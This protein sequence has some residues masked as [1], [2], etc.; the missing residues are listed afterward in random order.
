MST[1]LETTTAAAQDPSYIPRGPVTAELSF[2]DGTTDGATPYA[3]P[4]EPPAGLPQTNC[5]TKPYAVTI[6]DIRGEESKYTLDHD[7][8]Q[9]LQGIPTKAE[10]SF[11]DEENIKDVYYPEIEKIIFDNVP[12]VKKTFIFDHTIRRSKLHA[13]RKP[14]LN[15]HL[16]QSLESTQDRVRIHLPAEAD[17]LLKGRYRIINVWRPLNG[18]VQ[19]TPLAVASGASVQP[20]VFTPVEHRYPTRTGQTVRIG[21]SPDLRWHYWSGIQNDEVLLLK[22]ADLADVPGRGTPHSA[23]IDPRTPA[24]ARGRESIE[25]R[26]LVFG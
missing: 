20:E 5:R 24:G 12:G 14:V 1:Q 13:H 3:Y 21:Y 18:P 25:V 26:V 8:F 7:A 15:T 10:P 19:E 4:G 16:D 6:N 2:H 9:A 11:T 17:E 23:F 22:C